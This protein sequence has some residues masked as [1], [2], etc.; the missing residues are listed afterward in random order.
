MVFFFLY[1]MVQLKIEKLNYF[2]EMWNYFELLGIF[3]FTSAAALDLTYDTVQDK[4]RVLWTFSMMLTLIKILI[5]IMVF[6]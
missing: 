1:E 3:L 4:L 5:V 6:P 2:K